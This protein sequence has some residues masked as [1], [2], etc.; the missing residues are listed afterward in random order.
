MTFAA[1][2]S[3]SVAEAR[4]PWP[5]ARR[6]AEGLAEQRREE[7][8]Q[9]RTEQRALRVL[10]EPRA[11]RLFAQAETPFERVLLDERRR[12]VRERRDERERS[13]EE[14]RAQPCG[15]AVRDAIEP[16]CQRPVGEGEKADRPAHR[17]GDFEPPANRAVCRR[18]AR[19]RRRRFL[20]L[21]DAPQARAAPRSRVRSRYPPRRAPCGRSSPALAR[22][23]RPYAARSSSLAASKTSSCFLGR[24]LPARLM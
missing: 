3:G 12:E 13:E 7:R 17:L 6:A 14:R 22:R 5:A 11:S 16:S 15:S 10:G 18:V 8:A 21:A 23:Y 1:T 24:F 20:P 19:A 2:K 4:Q 9:R